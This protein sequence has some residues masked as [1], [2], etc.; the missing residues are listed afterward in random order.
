MAANIIGLR[1][2]HILSG[3]LFTLIKSGPKKTEDTPSIPKSSAASRDLLAAC[4]G[5]VNSAVVP[6]G[7]T[8]LPGRNI[9][10]S[11]L[12]VGSVWIN[13]F[14]LKIVVPR[15]LFNIQVGQGGPS[16]RC[17]EKAG[18]MIDAPLGYQ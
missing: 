1:W 11:S 13:R 14:L 9:R 7:I 17:L 5:L 3:R 18:T 8:C 2:I 6:L 10:A 4:C 16:S 12:G 15:I